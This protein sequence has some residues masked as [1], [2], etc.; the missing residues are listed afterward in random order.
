MLLFSF[1]ALDVAVVYVVVF[2]RC[3]QAPSLHTVVCLGAMLV[4][5]FVD[6]YLTAHGGQGHFVVIERSAEVDIRRDGGCGI[7]LV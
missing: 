7:G 4:V 5:F 1:G 2:W 3:E 6:L